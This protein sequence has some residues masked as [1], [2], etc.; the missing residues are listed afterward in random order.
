MQ[1]S[2]KG[3]NTVPGLVLSYWRDLDRAFN[4]AYMDT[5]QRFVRRAMLNRAVMG[6]RVQ[7]IA[8]SRSKYDAAWCYEW[9]DCHTRAFL[10]DHGDE[11]PKG[12]FRP[13]NQLR[14]VLSGAARARRQDVFKRK[15]GNK[16]AAKKPSG[17]GGEQGPAPLDL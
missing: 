5:M 10:L 4:S 8:D 12:L 16:K 14:S 1:L 17:D 15:V 3:K 9:E 6:A 2:E 11:V 7:Q 13:L